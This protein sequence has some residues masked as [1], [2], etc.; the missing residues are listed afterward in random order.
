MDVLRRAVLI[1]ELQMALRQFTDVGSFR[2]VHRDAGEFLGGI[3][4]RQVVELLGPE[5]I[6]GA[7]LASLL[8]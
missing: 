8:C 4:F 2:I 3:E 6:A 1:G 5:V 7:E